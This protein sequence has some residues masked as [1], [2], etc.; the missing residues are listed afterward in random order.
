MR[1]R[2]GVGAGSPLYI[3]TLGALMTDDDTIL[4]AEF[5]YSD[6]E[7]LAEFQES[8]E[9]EAESPGE[10]TERVRQATADLFQLL[11]RNRAV[12]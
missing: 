8:C 6:E 4:N 3:L 11:N 10:H 5:V 1:R 2:A 9:A 12:S 7:V